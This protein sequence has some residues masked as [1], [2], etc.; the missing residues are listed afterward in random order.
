MTLP[1]DFEERVREAA[2]RYVDSPE[3]LDA[4]VASVLNRLAWRRR[5]GYKVC[6]TCHEHKKPEE[7]GKDSARR[8]GLAHRCR[9]CEQHRDRLRKQGE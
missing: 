7:F 3:D 9:S 2:T 6:S 5:H 4:A 8:D 1:E